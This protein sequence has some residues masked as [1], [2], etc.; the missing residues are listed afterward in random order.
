MVLVFFAFTLV[1]GFVGI[2]VKRLVRLARFE[3]RLQ[4][5][6]EIVC[7]RPGHG[8][9]VSVYCILVLC[10]LNPVYTIQPVV[11]PVVQPV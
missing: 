1:V 7:T 3:R 11:K 9:V 6:D 10:L 2:I 5:V 4:R 8:D